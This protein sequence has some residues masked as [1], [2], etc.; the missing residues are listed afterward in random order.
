MKDGAGVGGDD[1][2]DSAGL[3]MSDM[4]IMITMQY[5]KWFS[6]LEQNY[7]TL[8]L[9]ALSSLSTFS[10]LLVTQVS[11]P[12]SILNHSEFSIRI[13]EPTHEFFHRAPAVCCVCIANFPP[14]QSGWRS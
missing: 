8:S 1:N 5:D 7:C 6:C 12:P 10:F 2:V 13:S 11:S 3:D 9:F 4:K 14:I